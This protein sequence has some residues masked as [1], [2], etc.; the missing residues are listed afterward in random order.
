MKC[1]D[2]N[3][4]SSLF[5]VVSLVDFCMVLITVNVQAILIK[6]KMRRAT[7]RVKWDIFKVTVHTH[8]HTYTWIGSSVWYRIFID[9]NAFTTLLCLITMHTLSRPLQGMKI[10]FFF[11]FFSFYFLLFIQ[12]NKQTNKSENNGR[13]QKKITTKF[14]ND[15]HV[16]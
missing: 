9:A 6:I 13:K 1:N 4:E 12:T 5:F 2:R 8:T 14:S 3:F 7:R 15:F 11:Y 10:P 16:N